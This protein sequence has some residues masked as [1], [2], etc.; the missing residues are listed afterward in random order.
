MNLP[1][2]PKTGGSP[3]LR[4]WSE[5]M[6]SSIFKPSSEERIIA[7]IAH[8]SALAF[9]TGMVI[10]AFMW[11]EQRKKSQYLAFQ[12]LQAY[13]YQSLGYTVWM[14]AYMAF[15]VL[16]AFFM[17]ALAALKVDLDSFL[18]IWTM[19]FVL[20]ALGLTGIYSIFPILAA[21]WC[22]MG[23]DFRYPI[24][25]GRLARY[26]AY[27]PATPDFPLDHAHE[28]RFAA[29]MGHFAVIFF[30]WGLFAPLGISL[31]EGKRSFF[32]RFQS[33]QTVIYQSI[34][35][36]IYFALTISGF[37]LFSPIYVALLTIES[38]ANDNLLNPF[39]GTLAI[40]GLCL[41]GLA[42]LLGPLYHIL[43]QW[44]GLQILL[45]RDFQYPLMGW[46]ARR[47]TGKSV[48]ELPNSGETV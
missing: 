16:A 43:G 29:S 32:L 25:G 15:A 11:A 38:G 23:R 47:W 9:G 13:G 1:P 22:A 8:I 12:T 28:E 44:A 46:L 21:V 48:Q 26:I 31:T 41:I 40:V 3:N 27:D 20:G 24:L 35:T 30:F 37:I 6:E 39:M 45:G 18:N 19:I 36:L 42:V 10:P 14:L 33:V 7:F 2:R 34:G 4:L 5:I 17:I